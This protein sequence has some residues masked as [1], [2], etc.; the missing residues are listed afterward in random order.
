MGYYHFW[1]P[2]K[3]PGY[4]GTALFTRIKPQQVFYGMG[5][6]KY[7]DEGRLDRSDFG[8]LTHLTTY[9][10]SGTSGEERNPLKWNF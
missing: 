7:D 4:S 8:G 1:F 10:P 5:I 6:E 2:A 3:K 9:F